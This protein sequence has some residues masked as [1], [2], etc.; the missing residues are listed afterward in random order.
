MQEG[1]PAEAQ[2]KASRSECDQPASQI[3]TQVLEHRG[4]EAPEKQ[5]K[6]LDG[7]QTLCRETFH[8]ASGLAPLAPCTACLTLTPS[9]EVETE[10]KRTV[11]SDTL[12]LWV[13]FLLGVLHLSSLSFSQGAGVIISVYQ[14]DL[15]PGVQL[16]SLCYKP[17]GDS[18]PQSQLP[19]SEVMF[20]PSA[21]PPFT[22]SNDLIKNCQGSNFF[23]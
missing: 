18:S 6:V 10:S 12:R 15:K 2:R 5:E 9:R 20:S 11:G 13:L 4:R 8:L 7:E 21:V 3:Q 19:Q 17:R 23:P 16:Q 1:S 14:L 22:Q